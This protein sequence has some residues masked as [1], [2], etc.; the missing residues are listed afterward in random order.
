MTNRILIREPTLAKLVNE[1]LL[2]VPVVRLINKYNLPLSRITLKRLI[3][4]YLLLDTATPE[5]KLIIYNS[6]FPTF[7]EDTLAAT[8]SY[9]SKDVIESDKNYKYR[10][11]YPYGQWVK[12]S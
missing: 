9:S 11:V 12:L 2:G 5:Q 3:D 10:G 4:A 8:D 1:Y 7:Q 6:L